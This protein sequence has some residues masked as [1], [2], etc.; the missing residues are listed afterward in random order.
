[1]MS[2]VTEGRERA[3]VDS[4]ERGKQEGREVADCVCLEGGESEGGGLWI[5]D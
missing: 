3:C 4:G 5:H 1:M 2:N